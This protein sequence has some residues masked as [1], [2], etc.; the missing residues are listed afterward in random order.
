M[1]G[2]PMGAA[3]VANELYSIAINAPKLNP[4]QAA[5]F[6]LGVGA[7]QAN[8]LL[9]AARAV[10]EGNITRNPR[11]VSSVNQEHGEKITAAKVRETAQVLAPVRV[12]RDV[13]MTT[14]RNSA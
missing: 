8:K 7:S 3:E 12:C 6:D 14:E 2:A 9:Q 1:K 5:E 11:D 4:R 10:S 13:F